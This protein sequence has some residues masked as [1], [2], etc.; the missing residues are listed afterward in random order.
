MKIKEK[1]KELR[2][3][4]IKD[5]TKILNKEYDNLH[6][7]RFDTKFRNIKDINNIR[8]TKKNIARVYTII[9]EKINSEGK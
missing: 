5:L 9:N 7:L 8:K 4:S 2:S 3:K 1:N 6:Q